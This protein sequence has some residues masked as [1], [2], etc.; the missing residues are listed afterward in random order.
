MTATLYPGRSIHAPSVG[1]CPTT[2]CGVLR[3]RAVAS[4]C[5]PAPVL[6]LVGAWAPWSISE[7]V[8]PRPPK[9]KPSGHSALVGA[10]VRIHVAEPGD[11]LWSI[12]DAY[13]GD[14]G[15]DRFIDALI[16]LNG[17]TGIQVGQ[18]VHLP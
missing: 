2:P 16:D 13:R 12:A 7:A 9:S 15:R 8:L 3:H 18:A 14:V 6:A 11:T 4:P 17:G 5:S 1:P 10:V